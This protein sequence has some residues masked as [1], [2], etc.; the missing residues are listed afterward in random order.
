MKNFLGYL[1][2]LGLLGVLGFVAHNPAYFGFFG[3][4]GFFRYFTVIPDELFR[5]NIQKAAT[6]AFFAGVALYAITIA[7]TAFNIST[8]VFVIG[9]VSGFVV[10][11]IIFTVILVTCESRESWSK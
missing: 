3:F 1:G 2:F 4:L 7:L 10:P 9:L 5:A 8:L 11:I 6:P